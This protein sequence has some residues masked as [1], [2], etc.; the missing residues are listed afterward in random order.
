[1]SILVSL[2]SIVLLYKGHIKD[3][4]IIA[5]SAI[6]AMCISYTLKLMLHIPRP[7][8]MLVEQYDYRFPSGHATMAAVV[9]TLCVYYSHRYI[10]DKPLR[11][12]L[13]LISLAWFLTVS[14]S[15][16]YLG[17]HLPIDILA[18]GLIGMGS[19]LAIIQIF[20][21]FRYYR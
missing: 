1:M 13:Y 7:M 14:C 16:L 11:Y 2:G 5:V 21:H 17:V 15:R 12:A 8:H 3:F 18:G 9:A 6:T 4:C 20:K 10:T 19:T